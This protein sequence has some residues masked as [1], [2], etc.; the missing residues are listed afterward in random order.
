MSHVAPFS[1]QPA[2]CF[3]AFH[4]LHHR[5]RVLTRR[6]AH[7]KELSM[8]PI[9]VT[10][11]QMEVSDSLRDTIEQRFSELYQIYEG[12]I[13][14]DAVV[15]LPHK[16][17]SRGKIIHLLLKMKVPGTTLVVDREPEMDASH[18]DPEVVVADA[19][20]ALKH[21]LE[22]HARIRHGEVKLHAG[23]GLNR[24]TAPMA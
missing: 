7:A 17:R 1:L 3:V 22:E 10:F 18:K 8:I 24:S 15:S 14:C 23:S 20:L 5:V 6:A 21:Q 13:S 16:H 4:L 12:V 2:P 19:F 11:R 9:N